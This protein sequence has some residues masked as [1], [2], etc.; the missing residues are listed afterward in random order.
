MSGAPKGLW[1][2]AKYRRFCKEAAVF[3]SCPFPYEDA[4]KLA[5]AVTAKDFD[6]YLCEVKHKCH[7]VM[8]LT[9]PDGKADQKL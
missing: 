6:V 3:T 2:V 1:V 7:Q 5:E 4:F 9:S 8:E